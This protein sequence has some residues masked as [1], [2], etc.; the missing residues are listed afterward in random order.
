MSTDMKSALR[1]Y[2]LTSTGDKMYLLKNP[3]E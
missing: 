2:L 1:S 3:K